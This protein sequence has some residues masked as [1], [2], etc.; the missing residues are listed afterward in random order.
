MGKSQRK[1]EMISIKVREKTA[2]RGKCRVAG[3]ERVDGSFPA[4]YGI[5]GRRVGKISIPTIV[6]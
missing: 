5:R 1:D 4:M 6:D 2:R 3:L